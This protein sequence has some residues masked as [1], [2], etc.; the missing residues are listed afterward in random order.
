MSRVFD[1]VKGIH[2]ASRGFEQVLQNLGGV[3]SPE[4]RAAGNLLRKSIR[5]V[6]SVKGGGTLV[7]SLQ[8]KRLRA[9]GGIPSA[10]GQPPHQQTG[11]LARSVAMG[12]VGPALRIGAKWFT[13][14]LLEEGVDT[15]I[16]VRRTSKVFRRGQFTGRTRFRTRAARVRSGKLVIARAARPFMARGLAAVQDKMGDAFAVALRLRTPENT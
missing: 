1:L 2:G 13:A 15:R 6:L 16:P 7:Q 4:M 11:R 10:P 5:K 8:T 9:V 12:P 3:R 14:P